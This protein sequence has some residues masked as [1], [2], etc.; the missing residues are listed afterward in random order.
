MPVNPSGPPVN[1]YPVPQPQPAAVPQE[2]V[3]PDVPG[4][5]EEEDGELDALREYKK[6]HGF[7]E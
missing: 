4:D 2:P 7:P 5:E 1:P 6:R 3:A